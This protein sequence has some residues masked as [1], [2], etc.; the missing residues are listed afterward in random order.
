MA[1]EPQRTAD[2]STAT[3][4]FAGPATASAL[5]GGITML[6]A[7]AAGGAS[8]SVACQI[9]K[10]AVRTRIIAPRI[11]ALSAPGILAEAT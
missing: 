7:G 9:K 2:N 5:A 8:A 4:A 11:I 3:V 6:T 10:A 1:F